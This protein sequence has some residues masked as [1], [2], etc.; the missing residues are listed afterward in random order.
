[1]KLWKLPIIE[2]SILKHRIPPI[3]PTCTIC[4]R[5]ITFAKKYEIK[6][7]CYWKFFGEHV[8]NLGTLCF[9]PPPPPPPPQRKKREAPSLHDARLHGNSI[10][11][12]GCHNFRPE[13]I[14]LPRRALLI[15]FYFVLVGVS[16][17]FNSFFC[18][19]EQI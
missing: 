14:A 2:G 10:P 5:R 19:N 17:K 16:H 18:C 12:I 7:R 11:K 9:E 8:M 1:M 15:L 4:E 6:M 13:L 3:W